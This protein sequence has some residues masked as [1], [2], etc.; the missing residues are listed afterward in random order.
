MP[1]EYPSKNVK[2]SLKDRQLDVLIERRHVILLI[3]SGVGLL[4]VNGHWSDS[5]RNPFSVCEDDMRFY[6]RR[7]FLLFLTLSYKGSPPSIL[8]LATVRFRACELPERNV[9]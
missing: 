4:A 9:H 1:K 3:T 2:R 5:P 8:S 7:K 6:L